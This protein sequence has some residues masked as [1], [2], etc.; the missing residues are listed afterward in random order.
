MK[1]LKLEF[2]ILILIMKLINIVK[3]FQKLLKIVIIYLLYNKYIQKKKKK[4]KKLKNNNY[5]RLKY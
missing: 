3:N 1:I 5:K 2:K 4:K